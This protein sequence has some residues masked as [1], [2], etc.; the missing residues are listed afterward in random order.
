MLSGVG[1]TAA[2]DVGLAGVVASASE[3]EELEQAARPSTS[4]Q[5]SNAGRHMNRVVITA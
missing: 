2:D 4:R 5:T 1:L 3:E